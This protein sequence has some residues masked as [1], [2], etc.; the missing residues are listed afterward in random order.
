M[1]NPT[2]FQAPDSMSEQIAQHIGKK[3][4]SGSLAPKERIQEIKIS[5]ELSVSRGSVRE[6][7]LILQQRHLVSIQARKGATVSELSVDHVNALYDFYAALLEM[8]TTSL[9]AKWKHIELITPL[10]EKIKRLEHLN[11]GSQKDIE[12]ILEAGFEVMRDAAKLVNNP[13]LQ[14]TLEN[15]QPA[16]HR[17]YYLAMQVRHDGIQDS[18]IFLQKMAEGVVNRDNNLLIKSIRVFAEGQRA[19][20]LSALE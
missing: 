9:A 6:A 1:N 5:S 18:R 7:L 10:L 15:L 2:P 20:V 19:A 14:E 13:Y 3:I 8:L 11:E 12:L 16:I 4:I 17:T